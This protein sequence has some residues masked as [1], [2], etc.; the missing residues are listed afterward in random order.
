MLS[1]DKCLG[2]RAH[3]GFVVALSN[4]LLRICC[5]LKELPSTNALYVNVLTAYIGVLC[6]HT[7]NPLL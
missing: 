3:E 1:I 7:N 6:E 5:I 2:N 4:R